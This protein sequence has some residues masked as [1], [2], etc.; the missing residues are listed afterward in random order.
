MTR[1]SHDSQEGT[2]A[3]PLMSF[4][5]FP[6]EGGRL[7]G[8]L[9]RSQPS[10]GFAHEGHPA[11]K[12]GR[13]HIKSTEVPLM[14]GRRPIASVRLILGLALVGLLEEFGTGRFVEGVGAVRERERAWRSQPEPA[15]TRRACPCA[16]RSATGTTRRDR[17]E[18][19]KG[20]RSAK[21]ASGESTAF[22]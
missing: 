16:R 20:A 8:R 9:W 11:H 18:T 17:S 7:G 14:G 21:L 1:T 22:H 3:S 12:V 10:P 4:G 6:P 13:L 15:R 2:F 5:H 19:G